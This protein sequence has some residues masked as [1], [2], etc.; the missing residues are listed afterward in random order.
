MLLKELERE[1][2]DSKGED[3][4]YQL[5]AIMRKNNEDIFIA[6]CNNLDYF[7]GL[8]TNFNEGKNIL[9]FSIYKGEELVHVKDLPERKEGKAN[10]KVL[11][12]NR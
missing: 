4:M 5:Y 2:L 10:E 8:L 12:R 3:S 11:Q 1:H 9:R 7:L 6:E